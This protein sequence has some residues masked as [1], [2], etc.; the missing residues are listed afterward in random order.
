[1]WHVR[2]ATTGAARKGVMPVGEGSLPEAHLF[3]GT[4]EYY[5]RYRLRYP[6]AV[7]DIVAARFGLDGSGRLLDLGTGPGQLA[8]PLA[9]R[10]EEVVAIDVSAEMVAAGER[11]ARRAGVANIRWLTGRAEEVPPDL[12]PF[13]LVT[14]GGA[15]H[16]MD[17]PT[18]LGRLESLVAPGGGV[19]MFGMGGSHWNVSEPWSQAV[20]ATIQR[21]LGRERRAGQRLARIDE[22]R[23]EDWLAESA[24]SRLEIGAYTF[25]H[26]WTLDEVV[27]E[28]YSTSYANPTLLGDR[29]PAF[30]ADLRRE[31]LSVEPSGRYTRTIACDWVFAWR[32]GE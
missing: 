12:G 18:V 11:Q 19:A 20:V 23:F 9:A 5:A 31:L 16:W 2:E 17:Q 22:R 24:F 10:F 32:P 25:D 27:G 3:A 13:R 30:E 15:F 8:I 4:A 21:W 29:L 28:L 7:L 6:A 26:T 1:M 14:I